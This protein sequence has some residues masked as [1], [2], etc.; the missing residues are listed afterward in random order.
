MSATR[1][2]ASLARGDVE[3][4]RDLLGRAYEV[5]GTLRVL[6]PSTASVAVPA[7]RAVP[8]PGRYLGSFQVRARSHAVAAVIDV[9]APDG[10]RHPPTVRHDGEERDQWA[11]RAHVAFEMRS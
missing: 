10:G 4:A 3:L 6:G 7:A 2:R 1:I 5:A 11:H 8:S 9:G